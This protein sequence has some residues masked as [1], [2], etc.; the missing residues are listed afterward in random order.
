MNRQQLHDVLNGIHS[1]IPLCCIRF[2]ITAS[3]E[4]LIT[5]KDPLAAAI[6]YKRCQACRD[7]GHVVQVRFNG[8]V[9]DNFR[10]T[11]ILEDLYHEHTT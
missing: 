4:D 7:D 10:N 1:G 11:M 6:Q 2:F 8:R 9:D 5:S 3:F